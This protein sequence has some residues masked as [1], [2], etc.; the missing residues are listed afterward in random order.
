MGEV[1]GLVDLRVQYSVRVRNAGWR[2]RNRRIE[3]VAGVDLSIAEGETYALVGE[4]GSGKTTIAMAVAGL[5]PISHGR[6]SIAGTAVQGLAGDQV[7][8]LRRNVVMLFQDAVGSLSPRLT[9]RSLIA[10]ALRLRGMTNREHGAECQRLLALVGLR[11][12]VMQ[13]YPHQLS[14]GQARRVGIARALA[15]EPK[16][17]LADEPTAGLDV[18]VQGEVINLLV[19]LQGELG[20]SILMISHNLNI[21]RLMAGRV[22]I[23]YLGRLVE[24]G[25]ASSIFAEPLH[26][27]TAALL[28]ANLYPDPEIEWRRPQVKG[29]VPSLVDRPSGCEFHPRCFRSTDL[30]KTTV[31]TEVVREPDHHA[32]CHWP[33]GQDLPG[34]AA[35]S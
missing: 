18:S 20:L 12:D 33:L 15:L 17:I 5:V 11:K 26:P 9:V 13:S 31:P 10:E 28:A 4:S 34:Q 24:Q 7:A 32:F 27:Y 25:P 8:A 21:V 22:G 23:M 2:G 29:E 3:A 19:R 14:G 6:L 30:C 35:R 1:L 16:L